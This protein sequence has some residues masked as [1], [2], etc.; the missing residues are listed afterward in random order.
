MSGDSNGGTS[1][2]VN[3][4]DDTSFYPVVK[5]AH[6]PS[7]THVSQLTLPGGRPISQRLIRWAGRMVRRMF[8]LALLLLVFW[9]WALPFCFPVTSRAVVNAR[10]VQVR[11]PIPGQVTYLTVGVGDSIAAGQPLMRVCCQNIDVSQLHL[12]RGRYGELT[13]RRSRLLAELTVT[14]EAESACKKDLE[15]Y[16]H[17][18]VDYLGAA[19]REAGVRVELAELEHQA[20]EHRYGRAR[21]LANRGAGGVADQE[22][23]LDSTNLAKVRI[24]MERAGLGRTEKELE[25]VSQG[26][27]VTRDTPF[28]QLQAR[29]LRLKVSRLRADLAETE[30]LIEVARQ[31]LRHEEERVRVL[32]DSPVHAPTSGIVWKRSGALNQLVDRNETVL[33]VVDQQ[34]VFVEA[35]LHQRYLSTVVPGCEATICL[36]GGATVEGKVRAVHT[37]NSAEP[38]QGCAVS[39]TDEDP[40][41]LKVLIALEG[42]VP[43]ATLIGR[44]AR[45]LITPKDPGSIEKAVAWLF[46]R[47][48]F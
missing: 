27:F 3:A 8:A 10:T 32:A 9:F 41:Q 26:L 38:E 2:A 1:T 24:E 5:S 7:Q 47:M 28:C 31:S 42:I 39:L 25:A 20:A 29:E 34:T 45:V 40:R 6:A 17:A 22:D 48:R 44:H 21:S 43:D 15:R 30:E 19:R 13:A 11:S 14:I 18:M 12:A 37:P 33:V 23:S 35:F 36:T 4:R 46:S 16:T